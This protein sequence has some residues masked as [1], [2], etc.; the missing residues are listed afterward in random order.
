MNVDRDGAIYAQSLQRM[1]MTVIPPNDEE[2]S[3]MMR[4]V[5]AGIIAY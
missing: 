1:L 3:H 4:D 5:I 2:A